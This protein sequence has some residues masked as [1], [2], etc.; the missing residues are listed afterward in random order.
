MK[1]EIKNNENSKSMNVSNISIES[2]N[3]EYLLNEMFEQIFP[4]RIYLESTIG[5]WYCNYEKETKNNAYNSIGISDSGNH[6]H[7]LNDDQKHIEE[8]TKTQLFLEE[9]LKNLLLKNC[10]FEFINYGDTE[11]VYVI[12]KDNQI[13]NTLLVGQPSLKFGI[14]KKEYDNLIKL[15]KINSKLVV[16]PINY[17]TNSQREAYQTPYFYQAR[18][19]ATKLD[20]YGVY[21]PEPFYRFE[22]FNEDDEYL[23]TKAMIANIISL[24]NDKEK[25][26]LAACKIGG[27]DFILE[28][29]YDKESHTIENTLKRMHLIA[30][31]E[32]I[33]IDLK[34]YLK[35][36]R[37][38]FAQITY[39]PDENLR[40]PNIL[41]NYKNRCAI[42]EAAIEDGIVLGLKLRKF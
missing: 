10:E 26:A 35:L 7:K 8:I 30:A 32:L 39:Y 1:D 18:C 31:R 27:G 5:K 20:G 9:I 17:Y 41:I 36:I 37:D 25:L 38:E 19:I 14:V 21:I 42:K 15:A 6:Y 29:E 23:I 16:A 3:L 11:L 4:K 34:D 24:Y 2:G 33:T 12:K 22:Y 40:N 28:K 13:I